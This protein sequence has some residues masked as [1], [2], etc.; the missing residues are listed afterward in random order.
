MAGEPV[1]DPIVAS[2]PEQCVICYEERTTNEYQQFHCNHRLCTTCILQLRSF[3]C[4][5]CRRDLRPELSTVQQ[6]LIRARMR[7]DRREQLRRI[8]GVE[9]ED[10]GD[11]TDLEA[12]PPPP[13][14]VRRSHDRRVRRPQHWW[15]PYGS[16]GR[17]QVAPEEDPWVIL[18]SAFSGH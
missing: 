15:H 2:E 18:V 1:L 4:P 16:G 3:S 7:Q 9:S 11:T 17:A 12:G 14:T 10:E 5:L 13:R 6:R 8:A